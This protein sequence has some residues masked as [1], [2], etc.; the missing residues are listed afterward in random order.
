M[1][2]V[3]TSVALGGCGSSSTPP[4]ATPVSIVSVPVRTVR[5]KLGTVAYR[6]LGSGP[7]LVLIMGYA[8]TMEV[9]DPRFIDDLATRFRVVIFD[10]AGVG[11][12]QTLPPP[13]TIDAMANQTSALIDSLHLGRP[14][15]VGWSTGSMIAQALAVLHPSEVRRLVLCASYPGTGTVARPSQT[16]IDALTNGNQPQLQ[17]DLFPRDR[18]LAYSAYV[19]DASAYPAAS[20]ASSSTVA[21]QARAI[22]EWWDG[23]DPAGT[24][25]A[26]I[27]IPT[28]I[29]DGTVDRLDPQSNSRT[30]NKLIPRS[31]LVL[32]PD[33]G[34]AFLFQDAT[35]V[36]FAIDAFLTEPPNAVSA[37]VMRTRLLASEARVITAAKTWDAQLK[38]LHSVAT[39]AQVATITRPYATALTQ[40][41]QQLLSFGATGRLRVDITRVVTAEENLTDDVL[42]LSL[43]T[44]P[45]LPTWEAT[46]KTDAT[47]AQ[48]ATAA[49]RRALRLPP[50]H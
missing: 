46:S 28:L 3:T 19:A 7:S 45:N 10:N 26:T 15:V 5:T 36:A 39:P 35:P 23:T 49:L 40:L 29:T 41:E 25:T 17:A 22:T 1:C 32:Y 18:S 48:T 33:A 27:L 14:D 4:S 21:A 47:T 8:G 20:P 24:H 34:H 43:T 44:R 38:A 30:L 50:G 13:L 2:A 42:A 31:R 37:N 11:R 12:T 16:A 9:W 6:V